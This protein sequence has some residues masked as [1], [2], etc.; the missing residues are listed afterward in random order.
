MTKKISK[1]MLFSEALEISG[2]KGA[3]IMTQH[4]LHCIGC[5]MAGSE[6]VEQGCAGHGIDEKDVDKMVEEINKAIEK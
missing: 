2:Q 5:M 3:D 4:G 6:T 1:D